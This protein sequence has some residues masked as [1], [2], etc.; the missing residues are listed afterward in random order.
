MATG[1]ASAMSI[2]APSDK[3]ESPPAARPPGTIVLARHGEPAL[4]RKI[5]LHAAGY[6]EW[7]ARYEEGGLLPGQA[8][9]A[10]LLEIARQA[11]VIFA[12]TRLRA[13]ETAEAVAGGKPFVRDPAFIEAPLPSPPLPSFIRLRPRTWGFVSRVAW[14]FFGYHDGQESRPEAEV[15]AAAV[16]DRLVVSAEAGETVLVLA[17]GFFNTLIEREL[18]RR[19]WLRVE[20]RGYRY[21]S[22]KR[23]ARG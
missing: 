7:W 10:G 2:A 15:R 14:W 4:S 8:P 17:H 20:G 5:R 1:L 21:W 13:V 19:G 3:P 23:F 16:T 11:D 12:S 9:P 6:R 18:K 22:A